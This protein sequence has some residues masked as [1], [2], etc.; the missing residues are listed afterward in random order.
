MYGRSHAWTFSGLK[1]PHAP[2]HVGRQSCI[3]CEKLLHCSFQTLTWFMLMVVSHSHLHSEHSTTCTFDVE[4]S[5]R[6]ESKKKKT[7]IPSVKKNKSF[8]DTHG[9]VG[10]HR[11][12]MIRRITDRVLGGF[13]SEQRDSQGIFLWVY[14]LS[15][16]LL[17]RYYH[18]GGA[19]DAQRR[20]A[21]R[22]AIHMFGLLQL[23]RRS[24]CAWCLLDTGVACQATLEQRVRQTLAYVLP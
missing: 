13:M 5:T 2:F 11:Y 3:R 10:H 8:T 4:G 19:C 14:S 7:R 9:V 1:P 22:L 23:D 18:V 17:Q 6:R 15:G 12:L 24:G 21:G 20:A 16:A